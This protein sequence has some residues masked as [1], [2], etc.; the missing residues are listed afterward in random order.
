M[1]RFPDRLLFH[2][3][4]LA[5]LCLALGL[6]ASISIPIVWV[7]QLCL[8]VSAA[9]IV[10][11]GLI[12]A[13][14]YQ[15][16]LP[17][18]NRLLV[19]GLIFLFVVIVNFFGCKISS[20]F[21]SRWSIHTTMSMIKEGNI[22]LDEYQPLIE[23]ELFYAI[24]QID[25]HLYAMYPAGTSFLALPY[26]FAMDTFY[27]RSLGLDLEQFISENIPRG[28]EI[29]I[30]SNIIA[31][32]TVLIYLMGNLFFDKRRHSL[33][34]AC[35]FAFCTSA[36]STASRAL[37]QHGPSALMLALALY[38]LL[39]AGRQPRHARYLIPLVSLLLAFSFVIRP[40]N[41]LS[42]LFLTFVVVWQHRKYV[43]AY[44]VGSL[45]V[46]VPFVVWNLQLYHALLPPYY[47]AASQLHFGLEIFEG[48]AGTLLSPS[49]GLFIFTPVLLFSLYGVI[50]KIH[51]K[52]MTMLDAMLI[53]VLV[54]HWMLSSAHPHWW[55]GHSYGPR[56]F[57]DV[58]PY[59]LYFL[60]PAMAHIRLS[61]GIRRHILLTGF[62]VVIV[63]SF[64]IHFR[65]ATNWDVHYWNT[66]PVN[67]D[68][69]PERVWDWRDMQF[70]RGLR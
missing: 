33:L 65:G 34:L 60:I 43:P 8:V 31:F 4:F 2:L 5:L 24:Y 29:F 1:H 49:R 50:L 56:Y 13:F 63:L 61:R 44:C 48:L 40:T 67:V 68:D 47:T 12:A 16:L 17:C 3:L 19:A 62:V 27:K 18:V 52:Q 66:V 9:C 54:L 57:T 59:F 26:V 46:G 64:A 45:L 70:L 53:A 51:H 7:S 6:I 39:L 22:D 10:S 35:I 23:D 21:D 58:L 38:L 25:E 55:G 36:W 15:A 42:I 14:N 37:W 41:S 28:L 69:Y 32:A 11:I 20:S 30:A